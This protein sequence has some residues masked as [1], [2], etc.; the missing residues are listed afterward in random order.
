MNDSDQYLTIPI[1]NLVLDD[2]RQER[3]SS[4][5]DLASSIK[6][7][8]LINP[9]VVIED[10]S[11]SDNE[12]Y[13][14]VCGRRRVLALRRLEATHVPVVVRH[15]DDVV[16][17]M[18][19]IS[20]NIHRLD[21]G[22]ERDKAIQRYTELYETRH[23]TAAKDAEVRK[24]VGM[25]WLAKDESQEVK[26]ALERPPVPS[27]IAAAARAFGVTQQT[28]TRAMRRAKGFTDAQRK[29][30]DE[31]KI[32]KA[33]LDVLA[34]EDEPVVA[35][36]VNLIA[37]GC[38]FGD[39]MTEVLK[40]G[41]RTYTGRDGSLEEM[42]SRLS[43]I[44]ARRGIGDPEAFDND[45]KLFWAIEDEVKKFKKAIDW[46]YKKEIAGK[47]P[48]GLYYRRMLLFLESKNPR[49]WI[50]CRCQQTG[51]DRMTC[52]YCRSGAYQIGE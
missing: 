1:E 43:R 44:P 6:E 7:I 26:E 36:V 4:L 20:E 28:I 38:E 5:Q 39:A 37:A 48:H 50:P 35:E 24:A 19:C 3:D 12:K 42:D 8:G 22:A 13:R 14:V 49:H 25:G 52:A 16:S 46:V 51:D 27:P 11:D 29:V 31:A 30:L 47:N 17:E 10:R 34:G 40:S 33:D 41:G 32:V 15:M 23:P 9:V 45:C 18:T 2:I 21:L